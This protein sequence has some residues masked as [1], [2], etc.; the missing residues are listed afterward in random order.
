MTMKLRF[1]LPAAILLLT[2][3][4]AEAAPV[5]VTLYPSGALV[6]E[7][8]ILRPENGSLTLSV[9][10]G[11][12][13]G[14]LEFTLSRG[15][16]TGT[17]S[18]LR[19]ERPAP[20]VKAV[21]ERMARVDDETA[22]IAARRESLAQE[23]RFWS[24]QADPSEDAQA[25]HARAEAVAGA[26]EKL[27][28][29]DA[30]L[31]ASLRSLA[32]ERAALKKRLEAL[33]VQNAGVREC[34]LETSDTGPDPV[35]VR[36][37]YFLNDAGWQ[38]RYRVRALP[39]RGQVAITMQ[40]V[41]RQGSGMNWRGVETTLASSETFRSVTPPDLP[42]WIID[43]EP[44]R[45]R[46]RALN[47]LAARA[48]SADGTA[49]AAKA[50][51]SPHAS[52][53]CW[54]LGRLDIPA[55]ARTTRPVASHVLGA[56]FFRLVRPMEDARAWLAAS[57]EEAA[58]P[59]LPAGQAS[60]TADGVENARGVFGLAPGDGEIFFGVDQ[61]VGVKTTV[62][63]AEQPE[64]PA[65]MTVRAWRWSAD[66]INGHEQAVN[67]RVEASAPVPRNPRMTVKTRSR[68]GAEFN[69]KCA[70]YEWNLEAAPGKT[71]TIVHEVTVTGPS[72]A[73]AKAE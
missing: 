20:E 42:D 38:P 70:C 43:D 36:W 12:D 69:E 19:E 26:L 60:F 71:T 1:S 24:L 37:S 50:S 44:V 54:N 18:V 5:S 47:M 67:V 56:T 8:E 57:L 62:L 13:E 2:S 31:A 64:V 16:V 55:G 27:A 22:L 53:L 33:G 40:A 9:P 59:L 30:A 66:I 65:G 23:R 7:E 21:L 51:A 39:E 29:R 15:T 10:A 6:T 68:P 45:M 41:M 11:V 3:A 28:V 32:E 49:A 4:V 61:L 48:P 72:G 35:R 25:R 58:L 14:S 52:G 46:P 34:T 73:S 63:P 17:T